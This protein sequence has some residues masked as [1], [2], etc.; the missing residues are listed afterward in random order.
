MGQDKNGTYIGSKV[1]QKL[2]VLIKGAII[3]GP[4]LNISEFVRHAVKEKLVREGFLFSPNIGRNGSFSSLKS[5]EPSSLR[6]YLL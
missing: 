2:K 1:P 3:K 6:D 4:Y 5:G